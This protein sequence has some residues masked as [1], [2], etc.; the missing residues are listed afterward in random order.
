MFASH[1]LP[2]V[3]ANKRI[4]FS[5][6]FVDITLLNSLS[7]RLFN[8]FFKLTIKGEVNFKIRLSGKYFVYRAI[9]NVMLY[10]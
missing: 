6:I 4:A 3:F 7:S 2:T 8:S 9:L 5:Y 1:Q 10:V